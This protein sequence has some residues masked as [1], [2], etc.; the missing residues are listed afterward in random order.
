VFRIVNFASV[1]SNRFSLNYP[2]LR[3]AKAGKSSP[4]IGQ[5]PRWFLRPDLLRVCHIDF[6]AN[7]SKCKKILSQLERHYAEKRRKLINGTKL[8]LSTNKNNL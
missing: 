6:P 3:R 4:F 1:A 2:P 8:N 5:L 7:I